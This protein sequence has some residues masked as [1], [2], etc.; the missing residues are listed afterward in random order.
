MIKWPLIS[1]QM[2]KIMLKRKKKMLHHVLHKQTAQ[3]F[4]RSQRSWMCPF[5]WWLEQM[6]F[7]SVRHDQAFSSLFMMYAWSYA[8]EMILRSTL[9]L[10]CLSGYF[11]VPHAGFICQKQS[12]SGKSLAPHLCWVQ[13]ISQDIS[14][15]CFTIYVQFPFTDVLKESLGT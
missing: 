4:D 6:L 15:D 7:V 11:T 12:C 9:S 1:F 10:H 14:S 13:I 3:F 5:R 8:P 2:D